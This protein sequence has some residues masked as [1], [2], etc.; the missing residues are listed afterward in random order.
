MAWASRL[1]A[2]GRSDIFSKTLE[3]CLARNLDP[4]DTTLT[5]AIVS[6]YGL[7][8]STSSNTEKTI[9]PVLNFGNDI[10]FAAPV[11]AFAQAWSASSVPD[12]KAFMYHFNSPNPWEG[13]WKG[14]SSH[15]LDI[16]FALQ[17]YREF[18]S[19]GQRLCAEKF[20]RDILRF[21]NGIDPWDA[22]EKSA[23][24]GSMV[25]FAP[26]K[27]DEDGSKFVL[28]EDTEHT[29]RRTIL[30]RLAKGEVLDKIMDA[31]QMF[32]AGPR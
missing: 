31:W 21:V 4:L 29:G 14:Y 9:E 10:T 24:P 30:Q 23:K 19:P 20:A 7:D 16:A 32:M 3:Q 27:G 17:N 8:T 5:P 12:T 25:Y 6:T 13:P 11:V 18:L 15:V 26:A 1:A 22:W 2:S 28:D